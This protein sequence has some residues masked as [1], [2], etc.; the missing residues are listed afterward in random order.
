MKIQSSIVSSYHGTVV[1][2]FHPFSLSFRKDQPLFL[3]RTKEGLLKEVVADSPGTIHSFEVSVGD[4][5]VPGM[6]LA[7]T[8]EDLS[9]YESG[10]D[11]K[12]SETC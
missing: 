2:I 3:I 7:Y 6:I 11:S 5:V 8:E 10:H 9:D 12:A 4:E 1:K